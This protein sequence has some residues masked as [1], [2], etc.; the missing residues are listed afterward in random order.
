MGSTSTEGICGLT[1]PDIPAFND[2]YL[3]VRV[4]ED[5]FNGGE[6]CGMCLEMHHAGQDPEITIGVV[7][8]S[9]VWEP[10]DV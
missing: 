3:N 4:T 2:G 6:L 5:I 1:T 7:R 8:G 9:F 10:T